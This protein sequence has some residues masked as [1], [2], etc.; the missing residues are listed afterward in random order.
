MGAAYT[1]VSD[2]R[3]SNESGSTTV[4]SETA[5]SLAR[6]TPEGVVHCVQ[7]GGIEWPLPAGGPFGPVRGILA[8]DVRFTVGER[9][10]P[11]ILEEG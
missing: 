5:Y 10:A 6:A 2:S 9:L 4:D 1:P 8:P 7:P 3:E 11:R